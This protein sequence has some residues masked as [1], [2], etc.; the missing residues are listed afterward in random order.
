MNEIEK[1]GANMEIILGRLNALHVAVHTLVRTSGKTPAA[2]SSA[3]SDAVQRV[4]ADAVALPL[5][6]RT[7]EEM[8]RVLGELVQAARAA[9]IDR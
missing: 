8:Q 4:E 2:M 7:V 3:L 9:S 1:V 5:P 6:E